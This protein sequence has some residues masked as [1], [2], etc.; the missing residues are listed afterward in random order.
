MASKAKKIVGSNFT[1]LVQGDEL[2]LR[3]NLKKSV[4]PS[5]TGKTMII[6]TTRGNIPILDDGQTVMGLNI[7]RYPQAKK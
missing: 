1:G 4:G 6:A 2:I 3:I 5:N 7:F